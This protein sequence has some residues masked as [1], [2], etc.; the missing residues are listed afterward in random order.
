[1]RLTEATTL[2]GRVGIT[3]YSSLTLTPLIASALALTGCVITT[4]RSDPPRKETSKTTTAERTGSA[5]SSARFDVP[6]VPFVFDFSPEYDLE[7]GSGEL[8]GV[9]RI[10]DFSE[11]SVRQ[12][13]DQGALRDTF[14]PQFES[15]F[16]RQGIDV[17]VLPNEVHS[18][19]DMAIFDMEIPEGTPGFE[20]VGNSLHNV[21]YFF[22]V[23]GKLW[24]IQCVATPAYESEVRKAC[25]MA[26]DTIEP[27]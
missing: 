10:A 11:I 17:T 9:V 6:M 24:Q 1:M 14:L 2:G 8:L 26:L 20:A 21:S 15:D 18:D 27:N 13:S 16:E 3:G 25:D 12:N 22:V 19:I 4:D 5:S 7:P 23:D